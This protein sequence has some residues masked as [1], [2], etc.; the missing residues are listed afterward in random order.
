MLIMFK[1]GNWSIGE[2]VRLGA[3]PGEYVGNVSA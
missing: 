3:A 1:Q 2:L